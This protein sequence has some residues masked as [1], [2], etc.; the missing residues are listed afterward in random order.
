MALACSARTSQFQVSMRPGSK[1]DGEGHTLI[2]CAEQVCDGYA[3]GKQHR[4]P[5]PQASA[6]RAGAGLEL[7]H[8]DLCG[9]ITPPTHGGKSF[10]LLIV[11]DYSRYMW[12]ELLASKDEALQYFKKI[13]IAAE[14]ELGHRIKAFRTDRGGEFNSSVFVAFCSEHGI[15]HNTTTL[16]FP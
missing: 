16:Y 10:F 8:G 6:Y 2:Q 4:S 14:V 15:K 5:F 3:L 1:G 7:V 9:H 11:D 13:K 12:L